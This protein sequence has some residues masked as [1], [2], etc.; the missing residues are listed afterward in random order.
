ME[1]IIILMATG[2]WLVNV[3][4][5]IEGIVRI[6]SAWSLE[7]TTCTLLNL[8]TN[9]PAVISTLATNVALLLMMM[10]GLLRMHLEVD[11]VFA[12]G[13]VLWEQ[14]GSGGFLWL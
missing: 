3:S 13:R 6:R 1:K 10:I 11:S 7:V 12:L 4:L 8:E 14:V 9:K 2:V 5:L